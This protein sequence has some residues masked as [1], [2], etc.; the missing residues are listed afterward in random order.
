MKMKLKKKCQR[1]SNNLSGFVDKRG[2]DEFVYFHFLRFS[3][4]T[5]NSNSR[6]RQEENKYFTQLFFFPFSGCETR[7]STSVTGRRVEISNFIEFKSSWVRDHPS[8]DSKGSR[9]IKFVVDEPGVLLSC[10]KSAWLTADSCCVCLSSSS[11][12]LSRRGPRKNQ[13]KT[14]S[15]LAVKLAVKTGKKFGF[16]C[17]ACSKLNDCRWH[18]PASEKPEAARSAAFDS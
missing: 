8:C 17:L 7:D 4:G 9:I 6:V 2:V 16:I 14:Q 18:Q 10:N 3:N 11:T 13:E 1:N 5:R 12:R 15:P